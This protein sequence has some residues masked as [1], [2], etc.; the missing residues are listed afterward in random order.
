MRKAIGFVRRKGATQ[1]PIRM[2]GHETG[3]APLGEEGG[4]SLLLFVGHHMWCFCYQF[5]VFISSAK[6]VQSEQKHKFQREN[7]KEEL[8]PP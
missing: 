7:I 2:N 6:I 5:G 1:T 3:F 8:A 4:G